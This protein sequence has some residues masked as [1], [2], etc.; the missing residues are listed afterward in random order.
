M[1]LT[2]IYPSPRNCWHPYF[3]HWFSSGCFYLDRFSFDCWRTS[4][5]L[6]LSSMHLGS[7]RFLQPIAMHW[8]APFFWLRVHNPVY[9]DQRRSAKSIWTAIKLRVRRQGFN[10]VMNFKHTNSRGPLS[11]SRNVLYRTL[12]GSR[13]S[14]PESLCRPNWLSSC[15][16]FH[17]FLRLIDRAVRFIFRPLLPREVVIV[18]RL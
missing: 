9:Q 15:R 7:N 6:V 14:Q 11:I 1:P 18:G 10:K 3:C 2:L 12:V 4:N 17:N 8:C 16:S 5:L 13:G